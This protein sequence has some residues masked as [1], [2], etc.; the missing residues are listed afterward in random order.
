MSKITKTT[1]NILPSRLE[2][3]IRRLET[4]KKAA[5]SHIPPIHF[6]WTDPNNVVGISIPLDARLISRASAN[7]IPDCRQLANGDWVRD[8]LPITIEHGDLESETF[9]YIGDIKFGLVR[10]TSTGQQQSGFFPDVKRPIGMTDADYEKRVKEVSPQLEAMAKKFQSYKDLNCD[11]CSLTGDDKERHSVEIVRATKDQKRWGKGNKFKMNLK[12]GDLLQVG[13]HCIKGYSGIDVKALAAFYELDRN[14]GAYGPNGSPQN[15]A[16]WG[17]KDMGVW[18]Y[19]ERMV[20][21]YSAREREWLAGRRMS[22]WEVKDAK[23]IYDKGTLAPLIR[24]KGRTYDKRP[25]FDEYG[26]KIGEEKYE[27]GCFVMNKGQA[28]L[29][30]REFDLYENNPNKDA[31]WMFQPFTGQGSVVDMQEMW[32]QGIKEAREYITV[33]V[34]N[35]LTGA[36]ELDPAT[37]DVLESEVEIPSSEYIE[38]MLRKDWKL[39]IVDIFPPSTESK[40]VK[41]TVDGMMNWITNLTPSNYGT[42][43]PLLIRLQQTIKLG[44]I[45]DK[46]K[47]EF[48]LLWKLYMMESF[49]NRKRK[50]KKAQEEAFKKIGS[51]DLEAKYPDGRWYSLLSFYPQQIDGMTAEQLTY[52][53][54][55]V[56]KI[57]KGGT[58]RYGPDYHKAYSEKFGWVFL[59]PQQ[60]TDF[61]AWAEDEKIKAEKARKKREAD[62]KYNQA[63]RNVW[64]VQRNQWP[65]PILKKIPYDAP[66]SEFL[67]FMGWSQL[68]D[69]KRFQ[70]TT[71]LF[72]VVNDNVT[73]ALLTDAQYDTVIAKFRPQTV[74]Q[75]ISTPTSATPPPAPTPTPAPVAQT[76]TPT[77][78][79]TR[80]TQAEAQRKANAA[81]QTATYQGVP[82]YDNK[83]KQI[84]PHGDMFPIVEGW[85]TWTSREFGLRPDWKT[86]GRSIQMIDP[87]GNCWVIFHPS[88]SP[89]QP[90]IGNYYNLFDVEIMQNDEYNGLKQNV[91]NDPT[92]RM[93]LEFVDATTP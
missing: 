46:T 73:V 13:T 64:G 66:V 16:G 79:R 20:Q 35:E 92:D 76:S 57:Y 85:V 6:S 44:Y 11:H 17:Y 22:L 81:R 14:I 48:L 68:N 62:R 63:V 10:N 84:N 1:Y 23:V 51:A 86:Q 8:V 77:S 49:D 27:Q 38:K 34:V 78:F 61:P 90:R 55:Y 39:K 83:G 72:K 9:E 45:G 28:L 24:R 67:D 56:G 26:K 69:P 59:T 47:N 25:K 2:Y 31:K 52:L 5:N 36:V 50:D 41:K 91:I 87:Q 7:L 93:D 15:P 12:K 33:P 75:F 89:S 60:W 43:A 29:K 80:I 88:A 40:F 74:S 82:K 53:R 42:D 37:G 32:E 18:D 30:G 3:L 54:E 70:H 19:A 65:R 4:V 21:Y 58:Y 71:H